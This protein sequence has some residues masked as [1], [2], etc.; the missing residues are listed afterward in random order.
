MNDTSM[1]PSDH[2]I[3]T[4]LV[5]DVRNMKESQD[6][7]HTEIKEAI[8]DLKENYATRLES[9]EKEI[10]N[11]DRVYAAKVDQDKK[12]IAFDKRITYLERICYTGLGILTAIEFYFKY[13]KL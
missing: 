7:F 5:A 12:D 2:D 9:V 8:T 10:N 3:L 6:R 13:F 11:A 1:L 4:T